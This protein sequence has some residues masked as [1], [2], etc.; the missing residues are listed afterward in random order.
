[1]DA[2]HDKD[3]P[4]CGGLTWIRFNVEKGDPRFGKAF[5]CPKIPRTALPEFAQSGLLPD[6]LE[7]TW[8]FIIDTGNIMSAVNAIKEVLNRGY[9]WVYIHGEYGVAK[10]TLL[11]IAIAEWFN[12]HGSGCRYVNM[13][14]LIDDLRSSYDEERSQS[15][16]VKR[17]N[18]WSD[19]HLLAID[20]MDKGSLT[21]FVKER[22]FA[23]LNKRYEKAVYKQSITLMVSNSPPEELGSYLFSRI[24]DNRFDVVHLNGEDARAAQDWTDI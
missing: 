9:G 3:C 19:V 23:I 5:P 12:R 22:R 7:R 10:T 18:K 6:D 11:K 13:A 20:E 8:D 14:D 24:R 21:E 16:I 1:M 4:I 17:M 2:I 15:E